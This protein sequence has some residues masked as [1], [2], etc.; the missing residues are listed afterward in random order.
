MES[1]FL[2]CDHGLDFSHQLIVV[3][4]VV[5]PYVRIQSIQSIECILS[6]SNRRIERR[7]AVSVLKAKKTKTNQNITT[8]G[9]P[10]QML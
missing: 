1:V 9:E 4:V 5:I 10:I 3:V 7:A 2:S 8:I 6:V